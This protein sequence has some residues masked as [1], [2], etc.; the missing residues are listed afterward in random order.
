[1]S[2][3]AQISHDFETVAAGQHDVED[4]KIEGLGLGEIE[5]ILAGGRDAD[6]M[7]VCFEALL[8]RRRKLWF[9]F[10]HEDTHE[11][12]VKGF[13]LTLVSGKIQKAFMRASGRK[14]NRSKRR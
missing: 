14:P 5:T 3:A 4:Q 9:V 13:V 6:G 1:M 10:H 8:N 2:Q 7:F 11:S 12:N